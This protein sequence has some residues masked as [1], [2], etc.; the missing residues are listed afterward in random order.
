[1]LRHFCWKKI[2]DSCKSSRIF[3]PSTLLLPIF[4]RW[5]INF[6]SIH[7]KSVA[8]CSSLYQWLSFV[9]YT[10]SLDL[11]CERVKCCMTTKEK[12]VILKDVLRDKHE[13]SGC[14]VRYRISIN[15][16]YSIKSFFVILYSCC[17]C[18]IFSV[19][20]AVPFTKD[21]GNLW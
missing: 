15:L 6:S 9:F 7:L 19:F 13:L 11:N 17:C 8:S 21:Y 3:F 1:M 18:F 10:F 16:L 5:K 20:C 2:N 4:C 12:A 14:L